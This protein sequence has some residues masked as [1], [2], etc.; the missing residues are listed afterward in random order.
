MQNVTFVTRPSYLS[1]VVNNVTNEFLKTYK[2][3]DC[4]AFKIYIQYFI[5][6]PHLAIYY[7]AEVFSLINSCWFV[8]HINV[9]VILTTWNRGWGMTWL[10]GW[11]VLQCVSWVGCLSQ[12]YSKNW[13][14]FYLSSFIGKVDLSCF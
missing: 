13:P 11:N 12:Q 4:M 1:L 7:M 8:M 3:L 10:L 6:A 5:G 9:L 14:P 2:D